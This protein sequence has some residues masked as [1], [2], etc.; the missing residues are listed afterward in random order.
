M[1]TNNFNQPIP[2][3]SFKPGGS[4]NDGQKR[5]LTIAGIA[6]AL[7]LGITVY[8]A[9]GKYKAGKE[10]A[11]L[12][13][14]FEEQKAALEDV[15]NK[16]NNAIAELE[17]QKGINAELDAKIN[18]QMNQLAAQKSEIDQMIRA[19]KDY[20]S[21]LAR[22][23]S[24]NKEFLAEIEQLKAQV[25]NLTTDNE[26][27]SGE[28]QQLSTNLS[29]TQTQLQTANREKTELSSAKAQ[30]ET[31]NQVLG[32][33]ADRGS[34]IDVKQFNIETKSV[35]SSGKEKSSKKAKKVDKVSLCFT[36]EA[37]EVADAGEELFHIV[38]TDPKGKQLLNDALGSGV[39]TNK[40]AAADFR[41][42]TTAKCNYRNAETEV[43][44]AWNP[45]EDFIAGK[46]KVEV[47]NKGYLVG[48][49][50]F[51]LKKGLF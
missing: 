51:T 43:C 12:E 26:R 7:L 8:L 29:S 47:Y 30:L 18:E 27:L 45:G 11:Q 17:Q 21:N 34:A 49:S 35:S 38:L 25:A 24:K 40:K 3:T 48:T 44:G 9:V 36:V 20:R 22:L 5:L 46:Y 6:I 50:N 32:K 13:L 39:S 1:N 42:T 33:K 2:P 10:L 15:E 28:N 19:R 4:D 16:Y 14:S 31:Q 41:Y 23:E 37:N